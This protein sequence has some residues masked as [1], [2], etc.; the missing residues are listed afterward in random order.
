MHIYLITPNI[1]QVH[2]KQGVIQTVSSNERV[3]LLELGNEN[4]IYFNLLIFE[5]G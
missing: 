2:F 1:I 5:I 4:L 3:V